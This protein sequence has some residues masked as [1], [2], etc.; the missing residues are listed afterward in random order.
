M[1][2]FLDNSKWRTFYLPNNVSLLPSRD[3]A[4]QLAQDRAGS[5]WVI[6]NTLHYYDANGDEFVSKALSDEAV[7][8]AIGTA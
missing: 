7:R 1:W 4:G 3:N 2:T 5:W 6:D 8:K